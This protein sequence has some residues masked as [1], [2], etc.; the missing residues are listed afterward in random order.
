MEFIGA[1]RNAAVKGSV[2]CCAECERPAPAVV[3]FASGLTLCRA[4]LA[5]AL[6]MMDV[7]SMLPM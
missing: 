5:M 6:N 2:A 7:G 4:C 3:L 1:P